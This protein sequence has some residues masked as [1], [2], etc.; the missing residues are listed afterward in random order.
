MDNSVNADVYIQ[1][2]KKGK[3]KERGRKRGV[4]KGR[5]GEKGERTNDFWFDSFDR[6]MMLN[7]F[8]GWNSI[9]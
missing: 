1:G 8:W 2:E 7:P 9:L 5:E 6:T 4:R 3:G